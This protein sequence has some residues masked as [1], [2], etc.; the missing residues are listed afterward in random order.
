MAVTKQISKRSIIL[1]P[2]T[3]EVS[4]AQTIAPKYEFV[5]DGVL[6][7]P[8]GDTLD[9]SRYIDAA[10]EFALAKVSVGAGGTSQYR[11]IVTSYDSTGGDPTVHLNVLQD[12]TSAN[13]ITTL[14]F[15]D[16]SIGAERTIVMSI[17]EEVV[18]TSC[19]DLC[20][21]LVSGTFAD[22]DA[23]TNGHTIVDDDDVIYTQRQKLK[24]AGVGPVVS[25]D[26][27][28]DQTIVT[29]NTDPVGAVKWAMLDETQFQAQ[30]GTG[31]ILCDGRSVAGSDYETIT[32]N[33]TVPDARAT[34][35]R[36]KDNGRGLDPN[37]DPALG[38]F[39]DDEF[40]SHTHTI[41]PGVTSDTGAAADGPS[42]VNDGTIVGETD[43]SGG[44]ENRPK[45]TIMNLFIRIN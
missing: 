27:G 24:F 4:T 45:T 44:N 8:V 41:T 7:I 23:I 1:S 43:A 32:G 19:E 37:G 30:M 40:E 36:F 29:I 18:G 33:S 15:L 22:L 20:L 31:W 11:I 42:Q 10:Q 2:T 6:S 34:Y 9:C 13:A 39:Q 16:N 25:D 14:S 5:V 35:L 17:E 21:T 28:N 3:A 12:F 38:S 26:V